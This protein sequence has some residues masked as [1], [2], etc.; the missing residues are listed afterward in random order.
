MDKEK[1]LVASVFERCIL[2]ALTFQY[3]KFSMPV[4]A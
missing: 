4:F 3:H 1:S 2:S